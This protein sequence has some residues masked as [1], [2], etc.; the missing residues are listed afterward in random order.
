MCTRIFLGLASK[1][2]RIRQF[3]T[4]RVWG[5]LEKSAYH[6]ANKAHVVAEKSFQKASSEGN[7]MKEEM[8]FEVFKQKEVKNF[9]E[10]CQSPYVQESCE[11]DKNKMVRTYEG[12][13]RSKY[14]AYEQE[15]YGGNPSLML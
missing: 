10:F 1:N 15:C 7:R 3:S 6:R 5:Q 14:A 13:C 8:S 2:L 12:Y 9:D 11:G 4:P